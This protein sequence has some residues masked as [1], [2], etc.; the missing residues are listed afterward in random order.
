MSYEE[1]ANGCSVPAYQEADHTSA[2]EIFKYLSS[3][4][5]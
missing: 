3:G 1:V 4:E 2:V 5:S